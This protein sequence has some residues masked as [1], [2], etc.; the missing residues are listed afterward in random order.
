MRGWAGAA[1]G[2]NS[3][4]HRRERV[5]CKWPSAAGF[6]S[7]ALPHFSHDLFLHVQGQFL[8]EEMAAAAYRVGFTHFSSAAPNLAGGSAAAF[9]VDLATGAGLAECLHALGPLLAVVNCASLPGR[10]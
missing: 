8:V 1:S 4:D 2:W 6:W 7:S 10:T 3:F 5:P 9:E